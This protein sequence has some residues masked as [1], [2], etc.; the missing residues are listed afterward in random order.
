MKVITVALVTSAFAISSTFAV[1]TTVR[2]TPNVR[3][4]SPL[5]RAVIPP[6][7]SG[8]FHPYYDYGVSAG[9]YLSNGRSASERGGY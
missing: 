4:S 2:H 8:S 6:A 9:G 1:A 5:Q 7:G 3:N